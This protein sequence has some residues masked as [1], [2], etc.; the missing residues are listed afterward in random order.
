[1]CAFKLLYKRPKFR[2]RQGR[3][4]KNQKKR[5]PTPTTRRTPP[6]P[7]RVLV[8]IFPRRPRPSC[9]R[10]IHG[11]SFSYYLCSSTSSGQWARAQTSGGEDRF[12]AIAGM[13]PPYHVVYNRDR[14]EHHHYYDPNSIPPLTWMT[15]PTM[16]APAGDARNTATAPTCASMIRL[17]THTSS[18]IG[19]TRPPTVKVIVQ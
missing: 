7:I 9:G 10:I 12:T 14:H 11:V 19:F 3:R 15:S 13:R 4:Q 1:M 18:C 16:C 2:A 17:F 6:P 8:P 5:W